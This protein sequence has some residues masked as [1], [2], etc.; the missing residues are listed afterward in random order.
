MPKSQSDFVFI[1]VAL[2]ATPYFNFPLLT[3]NFLIHGVISREF[4]AVRMI[5][6]RFNAAARQQ[7]NSKQQIANSKF[8]HGSFF[9]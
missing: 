2:R 6:F 8:F 7:E 9:T 3:F 5:W 4:F 1:F